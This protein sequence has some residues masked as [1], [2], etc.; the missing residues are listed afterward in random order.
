[1]FFFSSFCTELTLFCTVLE[2]K[3]HGGG[4]GGGEGRGKMGETR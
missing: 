4:G 2:K 1:M 3:L